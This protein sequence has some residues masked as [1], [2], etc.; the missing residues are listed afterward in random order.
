[1]RF[2]FTRLV[3]NEQS[4][5]LPIQAGW[6]LQ[7]LGADLSHS[8]NGVF[9]LEN[10]SSPYWL[11]AGLSRDRLICR[12]HL[13]LVQDTE[14]CKS[15]WNL[16]RWARS[17]HSWVG[18]PRSLAERDIIYPPLVEYREK[19][20]RPKTCLWLGISLRRSRHRHSICSGSEEKKSRGRD[21][22]IARHLMPAIP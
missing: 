20:F 8:Y 9:W 16:K 12:N 10:F 22:G 1:V 4:P 14:P 2:H 19:G 7:R 5:K 6:L 11:N 3:D 21:Q 15:D 13:R 17:L 18:K